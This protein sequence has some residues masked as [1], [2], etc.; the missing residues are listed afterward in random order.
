MKTI[1]VNELMIPL[2]EYATVP[3]D[4]NLYEAVLA[5]ERAQMA[6]DPAKHK[7]RAILVLDE[8]KQVVGKLTML[9][10]LMA[11]EPKYAEL[12]AAG[13]LSRS[14]Y[15]PDMISSMFKDNIL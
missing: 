2:E 15:S 10:I 9:D 3:Q 5:L 1:A 4:T 6:F 12:E 11:M 14:G 8:H 13:A 7:H